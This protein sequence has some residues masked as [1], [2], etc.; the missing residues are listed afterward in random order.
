MTCAARS[1]AELRQYL[2]KPE[3]LD[4]DDE[5]PA[6]RAC[7]RL[8]ISAIPSQEVEQLMEDIVEFDEELLKV[9]LVS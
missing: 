3:L 7:L 6:S 1:L 5:T 8:V 4:S 9:N 2:T